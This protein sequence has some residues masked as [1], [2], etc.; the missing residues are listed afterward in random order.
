[1]KIAFDDAAADTLISAASAAATRLRDQAAGRRSA[2]EAASADFSGAFARLFEAACVIEAEDRAALAGVLEDLVPQVEQAKRS[3]ATEKQRIADLAAWTE[4]ERVRES[5]RALALSGAPEALQGVW[6]PKPSGTPV[7][8]P[9]I[10]AS[11]SARSRTRSPGANSSGKSSADP[12]DLLSWVSTATSADS[13]LER[14]VTRVRNAW[15]GFTSAC[16]WAPIDSAALVSGFEKLLAENQADVDWIERIAA[17]FELAGN[18]GVLEPGDLYGSSLV[19]DALLGVAAESMVRYRGS[20]ML[21]GQNAVIPPELLRPADLDATWQRVFEGGKWYSVHPE[22][23]LLVPRGSLGPVPLS[24]LAQKPPGWWNKPVFTPNP[25]VGAPPAWARWGGRGL[26]AV[27]GGLTLWGEYSESYNENLTAHPDWNEDQRTARAW[28]DT[29]IIGGSSIA[30]S[31]LAAAG[32][33]A[34]AGSVVPGPG[35]VVGAIVGIT[36]AVGAGIFG[37]WVGGMVGEKISDEV[38]GEN[39]QTV[40]PG[41]IDAPLTTTGGIL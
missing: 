36:V 23:G 33:G 21:P 22:T 40:A 4:R 41:P 32:A 14:S 15:S 6:D 31:L 16:A 5:Q 24:P 10:S 7:A 13:A 34:L 26:G 28:E 11:F 1:M 8:P 38:H 3:A 20:L 35:T 39:V 25:G 17:A 19:S 27:G 30:G 29:A 2:A 12:A 18:G 9:P 37:G